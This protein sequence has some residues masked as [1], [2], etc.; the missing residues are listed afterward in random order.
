MNI[1][2]L[3]ILSII[4]A[5][6]YFLRLARVGTL[7]AF[8]LAGI[9]TGPYGLG[10]WELSE[11]WEF[12]GGIG[13]MF[14]WFTM[15]LEL[16]TRRLWQMR[17]T[18]FGFG[19]AQ[20]LMVV[21]ILFPI[22]FGITTWTVLGTLM[23][24]LL[25]AMSSSGNNLDLLGER[26][27]LQTP[28]GRQTFSILLFQDLL[29]I[30][31]LAMIPIFA[32]TGL[33]LGAS[34]IDIFVMSVGFIIGVVI[35]GRMVVQPLMDH[36]S[37]IKSREAFLIAIFLNIIGWVVIADLI[38]LPP[39]MGAFLGG[40]ML[41]ETLYRHQVQTDIAP[42]R[43]LFLSFFFIALGMGMNIPFLRESILIVLG[44]AVLLIALKFAAIYMVAKIRG[45]HTR[46][47]TLIALM[48]AQGGEFGLLIL[49]MMRQSGIEAIPFAHNEILIAIIIISMI[50]SPILLGVYDRLYESGKLI[51]VKRANKLNEI[52][53]IQ[54]TVIICGFGRVGQ[55]VARMMES[56]NI[57]YAAIDM[58]VDTVV[59][60]RADGFNVFYGDTT[61]P[62]VLTE[63]GF[64]KGKTRAVI[65]A[66]DNAHIAKSTV[67]AI[68]RLSKT[69]RIFAR[70]R[71]MIE[72]DILHKEGVK[73]A[74][75]ETIES[76]FMLGEQAM[77]AI[78]VPASTIETL[79]VRLRADNY[80][81]LSEILSRNK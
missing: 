15:G 74:L 29:A 61:K 67:R 53:Q 12:L 22:L 42:Y 3:I 14:L 17:Q 68:K 37:R 60:A 33:N 20:V 73:L 49:Q 75:P 69:V 10:L 54:P 38:G 66:L 56:Q 70:A 43:I 80:K 78:G 65:I 59:R 32:G 13:I 23:V 47:A 52:T 55:T 27:E 9:L 21:A 8:L 26:N 24:C 48:L 81:T 18:I 34:V 77:S 46:E 16:N 28:M 25:L 71:N 31:L 76:S 51:D 45:V 1:S 50:A 40:M 41:S 64:K 5:S 39:A 36:I 57:P 79:L 62:N 2:I 4:F 19:A 7:L 30:P 58:N 35:I 6:I 63:L 11:T 44:G 72:A